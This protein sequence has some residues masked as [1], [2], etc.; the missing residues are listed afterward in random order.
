MLI[1]NC[2]LQTKTMQD[3]PTTKEKNPIFTSRNQ[4]ENEKDFF[5][6]VNTSTHSLYDHLVHNFISLPKFIFIFHFSS[7]QFPIFHYYN[8]TVCHVTSQHRNKLC[9]QKGQQW[10]KKQP[11]SADLA[12]SS[13]FVPYFSFLPWNRSNTKQRH[14]PPTVSVTS[15]P[16]QRSNPKPQIEDRAPTSKLS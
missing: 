14:R 12:A 15:L 7:P 11:F 3:P 6:T 13:F 5:F 9:K 4:N 10:R 1:Q 2:T 8:T 16:N